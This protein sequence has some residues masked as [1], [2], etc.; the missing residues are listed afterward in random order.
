MK[1]EEGVC[2]RGVGWGAPGTLIS[3]GVDLIYSLLKEVIYKT[4]DG[5]SNPQYQIFNLTSSRAIST[6]AL[7]RSIGDSVGKKIKIIYLPNFLFQ[8]MMKVG[9]LE[10]L[11][12]RLY[13]NFDISN[14]KLK[15][16][17][18]ISDES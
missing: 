10:L 1:W 12:C 2:G 5:S 6:N 13:G 3:G 17:F 7:F 16:E 8:L 14:A 11:L 9:K 18:N 4:L 15:K